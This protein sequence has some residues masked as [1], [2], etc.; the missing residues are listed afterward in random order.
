VAGY[1]EQQNKDTSVDEI[2]HVY[3]LLENIFHTEDYTTV[4][5]N[6]RYESVHCVHSVFTDFVLGGIYNAPENLSW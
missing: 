3:A 2:P 5:S 1:R 4:A 6:I